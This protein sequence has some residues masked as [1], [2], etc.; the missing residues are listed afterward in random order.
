MPEAAHH[1]VADN[2]LFNCQRFYKA[3]DEADQPIP[4][5]KETL[6]AVREQ[7]DE[8]FKAGED[9][10]KL[11]YGRAWVMDKILEGIWQRFDWPDCRHIELIAVGGY[12]RGELHPCSDVD[13]LILVDGVEAETFHDSISGFLTLLWD[14]NL[15]IG[16]SVRSLKECYEEARNDI[17]IATNL[18]ESRTIVGTGSLHNRMYDE[19]T[20]EGAWTDKEFFRAKIR[21][22]QDRHEKTNNTEYNLEPNLK[23]S[24]GGLRDLQTI[25]WVAKRHFGSTYIRDLVDDGFLTDNE[26]ETLNKGELYLWTVRYALH[27]VCNRHEDRLLFDHQ[28]ALAELFGYLDN[29]GELAVEQ[30]MGKYYRV[31][32]AMSE[33]NHML[34]QHFD[35]AILRAEEEEVIL[36]LNKRFRIHNDFIEVTYDKVFE[37]HPFALMEIFVLLAGNLNIKGVRAS[38]IRLIRDHRYLINDDFRNDIRNTSLFMEIMRSPDRV[39]TELKRMNKYGILGLYLPEF[40]QIV[41]QMQHDLFHIYTVDAHTLKLIQITRQFRHQDHRE[42]FPIAHRIANQLPKIELLYIAGLYHD[43]AKG[44]GG[45]HSALGAEDTLEF[46]QRHHLGKW[47]S[48]LIAWLVRNHLLMSMTAQRKDISDPEVIQTFAEQVHDIIHLDYLYILTVADINATNHTLWNNWRATLMRTLYTETKLALRRGL[49]NPVEKEDLI[50]Q[51]Q[52]ETLNLLTRHGLQET[53]IREFWS[54]LGDDYFLR[55]TSQS[56]AWHTRAIL[57]HNQPDIPLVLIRQTSHRLHEGATEIFVYMNDLPNLFAASVATLDQ[58]NLNIQDARIIVADDGR[59]LNTY[60]VLTEDNQPLS[61]NPDYLNQIQQRMVEELDDPEDYPDIIQRRV[62]R[63]LKLFAVPTTVN[64]STN[65]ASQETVLEVITPDRPGLL[66]RIGRI[67]V[68]NNVC[69]H[70]AK[71]AS[72]GERVEDFFFITDALGQPIADPVLCQRL[73]D[74]ICQQLDEHIQ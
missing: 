53:E 27:M 55:E 44:R 59:T 11:I 62:P 63:Q 58:L 36:P 3:L 65:P 18:I 19:V 2:T 52:H 17:T 51:V 49:E 16:S 46:C 61:E 57:E 10:R 21:E 5:L 64:I 8:R 4:L 29:E 23:T 69:V 73:Q 20:S 66:A 34:L 54:T 47:D 72:I 43:I 32:K 28:R 1:Q 40:G 12:G 25:G 22:Q 9:I 60:T 70:K 50:E 33:F 67:F 74:D 7:M 30:F 15:D 31:A 41:G 48:H 71:I 45:D 35:E 39:S 38:T 56:I 42:K 37:H 14:I 13:L 26:L 24:P 6:K 68:E